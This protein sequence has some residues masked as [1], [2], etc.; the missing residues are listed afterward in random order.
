MK[1]CVM[2]ENFAC[3]PNRLWLYLSKPTLNNWCTGVT[4]YEESADGMQAKETNRD[5]S[6]NVIVY[7]RREKGRCMSGS[8]RNGRKNGNFTVILL[9][10]GDSTSLECTVE[11]N[12]LGLFG[13]PQKLLQTRMELLHK[14][15]GD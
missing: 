3:D 13:K 10:G 2:T 11:M 15:I 1:S 9:G 6:V 5:G 14:A 8:F 4:G 7:T 12:G